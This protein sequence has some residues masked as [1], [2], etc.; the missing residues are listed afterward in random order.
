MFA[1]MALAAKLA[2]GAVI[3]SSAFAG[4]R[5]DTTSLGGALRAVGKAMRGAARRM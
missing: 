2:L 5:G 4:R 1:L 3:R